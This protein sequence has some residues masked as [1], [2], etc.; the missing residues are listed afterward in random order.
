M[1][2]RL[3]KM[4]ARRDERGVTVITIL[5]GVVIAGHSHKAAQRMAGGVLYHCGPVVVKVQL[6]IWRCHS[7]AV[8]R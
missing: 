2:L 6:P 3:S 4:V 8:A 5:V 7:S 1:V